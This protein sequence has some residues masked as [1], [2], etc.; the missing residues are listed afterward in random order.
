MLRR[1]LTAIAF[2]TRIPVNPTIPFNG[3][4][5]ARATV[6]FPV[7]GCLV[8]LLQVLLAQALQNVSVPYHL[9]AVALT[10]LVVL[11]GG[12]LHQDGLADMADG[13]GGGY[14]RE[15]V[16]EIMRDSVIGTYGALALL[17]SLA[18][19]IAALSVLL[20]IPGAW[21]WIVVA[22]TVSRCAIWLGWLLP[23]ARQSGTGESLT[24]L[25]NRRE[26]A[27]ATA[28]AVFV[29]AFSVGYQ[30]LSVLV[31]VVIVFLLLAGLAAR[32]IGGVT[33]DV[34]GAATE[35][36]EVLLLAMGATLVGASS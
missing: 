25:T 21:V 26:V 29:S 10:A 13:F 23:Y 34:L 7:V 20:Q 19:R 16:L 5:V 30:T 1:L 2:L 17:L 33:G 4:D 22:G 31:M 12:G 32:K 27:G 24:R 14:T 9:Q 28:F 6:F 36:S 3:E 15:R 35:V 11:I 8:A 18:T